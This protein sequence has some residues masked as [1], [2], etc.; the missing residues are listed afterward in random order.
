MVGLILYVIS[1]AFI[2]ALLAVLYIFVNDAALARIPT[3][4]L[5]LTSSKRWSQ[6][7]F[8]AVSKKLDENPVSIEDSLPPR[9]GRRYI[10]VGGSGFLGGWIVIHL[11]KRGELPS[12]IRII[13]LRPPNRLDFQSGPAKDVPFLKADISNPA[14]VEAAFTAP[15]PHSSS[16]NSEITV[17]HTA[18]VIRF[19]ERHPSLL[20]LSRINILGTE[21]VINASR[22][23]GV[24]ILIFTSSGSVSQRSTRL[25]LIPGLEKEPRNFVQVLR[26]EEPSELPKTLDGFA[27][28]YSWTKLEAETMVRKADQ[29]PSGSKGTILRTGCLRPANAIYGPGA[30]LFEYTITKGKENYTFF[31]NVMTGN[32]YVENC[33]LSHLCYEQCLINLAHAKS[34]VAG[35]TLPD[36]GGQM[37]TVTDQEQ[38]VFW[39]EIYDAVAYFT[40]GKCQHQIL[41]PTILILVSYAV[42]QYYLLRHHLCSSSIPVLTLVGNLLPRLKGDLQSLQPSTTMLSYTH[43]LID[44]SRAR[45]PPN[46]GG[47]G[48]KAPWSALEALCKTIKYFET[49]GS[50]RPASTNTGFGHGK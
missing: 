9:T 20:P 19:Y 17:F 22:V 21:N 39:R 33:S 4:V 36:I 27:C 49:H 10:V 42:E 43:L 30:D 38:P 45:L 31:P 15:W 26:D 18:A 46:K 34:T 47:L 44:D 35:S 50:L 28:C 3:R 48:Y 25:L 13:D 7:D 8:E 11:L 1:A 16:S 23:A 14:Q 32:V 2:S 5:E 6:A 24:S 12:N 41:P 37:F 29:S 40:N